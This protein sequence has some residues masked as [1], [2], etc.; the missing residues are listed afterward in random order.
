M[1]ASNAQHITTMNIVTG[2]H[3]AIQA[4][5]LERKKGKN[6]WNNEMSN[7]VRFQMLEI[8]FLTL[9]LMILFTLLIKSKR[10]RTYNDL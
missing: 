4:K 10:E 1:D 3:E 5:W 6:K 8:F 9:K 7:Q 2:K